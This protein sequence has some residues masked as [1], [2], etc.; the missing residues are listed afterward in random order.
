VRNT[1]L[2][3]QF[4]RIT[5]FDPDDLME[6]WKGK[7]ES[8]QGES[9]DRRGFLAWQKTAVLNGRTKRWEV[10][11][12]GEKPHFNLTARKVEKIAETQPK[13]D[14]APRGVVPK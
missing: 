12:M 13:N 6:R 2:R 1:P 7:R 9:K 4:K 10:Q 8:S 11:K 3:K 14:T 5:N